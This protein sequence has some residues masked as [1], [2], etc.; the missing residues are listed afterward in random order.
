MLFQL[1]YIA[2]REGRGTWLERSALQLAAACCTSS[3][4]I[5]CRMF[6]EILCF[7]PIIARTLWYQ[8]CVPGQDTLTSGVSLYSS[9]NE[10]LMGQRWQLFYDKLLALHGCSVV[11]SQES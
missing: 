4:L 7:S 11:C 8:F 2:S 9:V 5:G 6:R 10:Y 3:R 1:N